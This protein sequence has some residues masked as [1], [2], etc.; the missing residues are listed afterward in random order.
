MLALKVGAF[1]AAVF[2]LQRQPGILSLVV[3]AAA[4]GL[5]SEV[6]LALFK[7]REAFKPVR[8]WV[9][10]LQ[11]FYT[12]NALATAEQL[13]ALDAGDPPERSLNDGLAFTILRWSSGPSRLVFWNEWNTFT[14]TIEASVE[15]KQ[16]AFTH[17]PGAAVKTPDAPQL[18]IGT[19]VGHKEF[20]LSVRRSGED[21]FVDVATIP[22]AA[23]GDLLQRG[24]TAKRRS[25]LLNAYGWKDAADRGLEHAVGDN[26]ISHEQFVVRWTTV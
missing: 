10:P 21:A 2:Y 19:P 17:H 15:Y 13:K 6:A 25:F 8:V 7:E 23:F 1:A 26:A 3:A 12:T 16:L 14:T 20:R 24:V 9:T 4:A 18:M 5:A 22:H 11:M